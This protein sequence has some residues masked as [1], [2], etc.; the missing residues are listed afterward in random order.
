LLEFLYPTSTASEGTANSQITDLGFQ[1]APNWTK[2]VR[3]EVFKAVT[4]K[5]CVF[6]DDTPCGSYNNRRFGGT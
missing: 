6:C 4:M 2:L 5:N 1:K 3:F